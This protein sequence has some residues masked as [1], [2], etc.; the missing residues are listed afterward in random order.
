MRQLA[1]VL[2]PFVLGAAVAGAGF[3]AFR[4]TPESVRVELR[5]KAQIQAQLQQQR[6]SIESLRAQLELASLRE[7]EQQLRVQE[8]AD[9][10]LAWRARAESAERELQE[11]RNQLQELRNRLDMAVG[12]N[13]HLKQTTQDAL[14]LLQDTRAQIS[15]LV[16]QVGRLRG[17]LAVAEAAK[18]HLA[19]QLSDAQDKAAQ[20]RE[21]L[22]F[23]EQL[24]PDSGNSSEVSI[25]AVE[26]TPE[27]R[28]LRY[29][30]L[31]MRSS[32]PDRDFTGTLRFTATGEQ[33]GESA[34]IDLE[35]VP[36]APISSGANPTPPV[37]GT[38]SAASLNF[39][40][41]Q[42]VS[43]YLALP[44]DFTPQTITVRVLE[45]KTVR[46]EHTS[47]LTPKE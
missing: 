16:T 42:R 2:L 6:A 41:Y 35:P 3:Y 21:N 1:V 23:F 47:T 13:L 33:N 38:A 9:S 31:V 17:E 7:I 5:E 28:L 30:L 44:A 10:G 37:A 20:L 19:Q 46:A 43:G 40:H 14:R 25:R 36:T 27:G 29:R 15:T 26:F 22:A 18:T 24:L 34:T 32:R 8:M 11:L 12:E 39:R 45:G 4:P